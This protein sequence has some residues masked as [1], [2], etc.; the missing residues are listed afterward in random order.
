MK[1]P[2]HPVARFALVILHKTD[3]PD[4]GLE[5]SLRKRFEEVSAIIPEQA[6]FDQ[7]DPRYAGLFNFHVRNCIRL[8]EV[9]ISRFIDL[10]DDFD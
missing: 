8:I 1:S 4:F 6:G 2:K 5:V 3:F 10:L 7:Y 9:G